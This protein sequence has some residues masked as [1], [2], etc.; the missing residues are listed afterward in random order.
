LFPDLQERVN[1]VNHATVKLGSALTHWFTRYRR[2]VGV[3]G[4]HGE[5]ST[6]KIFPLSP[7]HENTSRP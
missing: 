1:A 6:G 5:P 7:T 2:S 4:Q 3:G